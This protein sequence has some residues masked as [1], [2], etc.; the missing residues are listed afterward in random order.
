ME[1]AIGSSLRHVQARRTDHTCG[2]DIVAAYTPWLKTDGVRASLP[3]PE[4]NAQDVMALPDIV[5]HLLRPPRGR[6]P[7]S[8]QTD[9]R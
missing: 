8:R 9:R 3:P 5:P 4:Y 1:Q 7:L 2:H 6:P